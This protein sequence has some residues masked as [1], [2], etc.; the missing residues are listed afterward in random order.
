MNTILLI[1]GLL[2]LIISA[3]VIGFIIR[4]RKQWFNKN[5][6]KL[7]TIVVVSG[8]LAGSGLLLP[9]GDIVG[10]EP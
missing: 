7:A 9:T 2:L 6:K 1:I 3:S 4:Y 10:G 8:I 5:K